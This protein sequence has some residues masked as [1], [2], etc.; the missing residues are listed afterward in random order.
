[1]PRAMTNVKRLEFENLKQRGTM[2]VAEYDAEFTNLSEYAPYIVSNYEIKAR[3]FEDGL[4]P[5]VRKVIRPLMLSTYV[6]VLNR[7]ILIEQ[8]M[9]DTRRYQERKRQHQNAGRNQQQKRANYGRQAGR[10]EERRQMPYCASCRRSHFGGCK[11]NSCF[12]CV[13]EG[14]FK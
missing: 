14:H 4:K 5:E 1:M 12:N 13:Q 3:R 7:A 6:D 8:D 10:N 9:E 2:S 11:T